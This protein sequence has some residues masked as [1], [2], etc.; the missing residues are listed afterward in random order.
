MDGER[1]RVALKNI[2]EARLSLKLSASSADESECASCERYSTRSP[3]LRRLPKVLGER[4]CATWH[5]N[6]AMR[7]MA[8]ARASETDKVFKDTVRL[9][10]RAMYLRRWTKAACWWNAVADLAWARILRR[11]ESRSRRCLRVPNKYT[12]D[13]EARPRESLGS[14]AVAMRRLASCSCVC[15]LHD[16][17]PPHRE[18]TCA[19]SR[20]G[21]ERRRLRG[22]PPTCE[23][24][25]RS[26]RF[27]R[28]NAFAR[29]FSKR[30]M[31]K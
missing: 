22:R 12:K 2:V 6:L 5:R 20:H 10:K 17:L 28:A 27:M 4:R 11:K 23:L 15:S 26:E 31:R 30:R 8:K 29:D 7:W 14:I 3:S 13:S 25:R 18:G 9:A 1:P 24:S 16:G 19:R 21:G